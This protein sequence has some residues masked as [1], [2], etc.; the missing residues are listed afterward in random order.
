MG[1]TWMAEGKVKSH[2]YQASAGG[3]AEGSLTSHGLNSDE[4]SH[5]GCG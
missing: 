2:I 4:L 5:G 3:E 1:C